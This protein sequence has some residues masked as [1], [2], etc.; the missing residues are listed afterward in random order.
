M[1]AL[2]QFVIDHPIV[3]FVP[4]V[5][6]FLVLVYHA[7]KS[8]KEDPAE[9]EEPRERTSRVVIMQEVPSVFDTFKGGGKK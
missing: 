2:I 5:F 7:V 4:P 9:Q 3:I 6:F 8:R 1:I